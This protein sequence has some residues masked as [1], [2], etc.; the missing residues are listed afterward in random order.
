MSL[1]RPANF[2]RKKIDHLTEIAKTYKAK[3]LAW[4]KV[5]DAG[6]Q[7]PIAKFFTEEQMNTLLTAMNAKDMICYY[8]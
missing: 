8:L 7:G 2:S 5:S 4:L 1:E 3:G 6:V